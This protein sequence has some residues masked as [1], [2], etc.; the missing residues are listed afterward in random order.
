[1]RH[2]GC[3]EKIVRILQKIYEGT[4]RA[5]TAAGKSIEWFETFLGVL[6]GCVLSPLLFNMFLETKMSRALHEV[7]AAR[8][9]DK[10]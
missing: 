6:Q 4:F 10:W 7:D 3:P 9:C 1:M 2:M 5:V 8:R